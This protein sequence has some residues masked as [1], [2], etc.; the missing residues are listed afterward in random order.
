MIEN[1]YIVYVKPVSENALSMF[2]PANLDLDMFEE[3]ITFFY[4]KNELVISNKKKTNTFRV[5]DYE[6]RPFIVCYICLLSLERSI[7]T[8]YIIANDKN[9]KS[10]TIY[11][12]LSEPLNK[13][14]ESELTLDLSNFI[15]SQ[16]LDNMKNKIS[17]EKFMK[18]FKK[19][20]K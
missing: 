15:K 6:V 20:N 4:Y 1:N 3:E 8:K 11:S 17:I 2:L 7:P 9:G 19:R 5:L 10:T 16:N 13:E 12:F 14:K 18:I